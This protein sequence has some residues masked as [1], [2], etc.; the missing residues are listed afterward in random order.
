MQMSSQ[1][2]SLF[3]DSAREL[4]LELE[5]T[6]PYFQL[7]YQNLIEANAITNLT[8][9]RDER[10]IILKHFVDSLS[11]L[12]SGKLEGSLRVVDVGTGA[13]FP[14]LPL[15]IVR[16]ELEM[17]FLD[18]TQKKIAFI[19][20][21]CRKMKLAQTHCIWGRAEE[22]GH[23]PAHRETYDRALSRAVSALNTLSELCLPLVRVGG[24]MIAQKSVGVEGEL[25]QAQAAIQK[26]GGTVQE[27]ITFQLP[28]LGE[29]RT[30][31]VIE[32]T[33][34]TPPSYPRRTGVPAKN[35]LS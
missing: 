30:L 8:A 18:A 29:L 11:C 20:G 24:F 19:E 3:L 25:E 12:K 6:L 34:P 22:L 14:G 17:T 23:D 4:G 13:G 21:V 28:G 9:I 33:R 10:G 16:P 26:L 32:K 35:P 5:P 7:L 15:K 1:G 2:V 31:I 27:V